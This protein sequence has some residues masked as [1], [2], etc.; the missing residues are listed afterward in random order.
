MHKNDLS[1][2]VRATPCACIAGWGGVATPGARG[3]RRK[4]SRAG[5]YILFI[6]YLNLIFEMNMNVISMILVLII[7]LVCFKAFSINK[8]KYKPSNKVSSVFQLQMRNYNLKSMN[9]FN[10]GKILSTMFLATSLTLGSSIN[11]VNA[12][13]EGV[14]RPDL[15]P[16]TQTTVID[17]ANFL[18]K[19]QEKRIIDKIGTL[20][21]NTGIKFR[22]LCQSYPETPG[23][24]IKDYWGIDDN[25]V[26]MVVDK[27]EGF[28]RKG[29]PSNII[30]LNIGKNVDLI[31]PNQFWMRVTNKL[32]NQPYVKANGADTAVINAVEAITYCLEQKDCVD[33][34]FDFNVL[35]QS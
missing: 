32:G 17:V 14:N 8:L 27:G 10:F 25:T 12:R 24:A 23:L 15:L 18:A 34:P 9:D 13:P 28:N 7:F 21:K 16:K 2:E 6:C 33:L 1:F 19:G 5:D 29:I 11:V 20:E 26:V 30:N 31:L 3:E 22:I 35:T 4:L